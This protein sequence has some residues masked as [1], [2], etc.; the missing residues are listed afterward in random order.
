MGPISMGMARGRFP[1]KHSLDFGYE[2]G[3]VRVDLP[4]PMLIALAVWVD[5]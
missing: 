5:V 3:G 4:V 1:G 2:N